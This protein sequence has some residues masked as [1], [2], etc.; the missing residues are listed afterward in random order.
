MF[1]VG[2]GAVASHELGAVVVSLV[3][4]EDVVL[5]AAPSVPPE[6]VPALPVEPSTVCVAGQDVALVVPVVVVSLA[7]VV[8]PA[9]VPLAGATLE[10]IVPLVPVVA[11]LVDELETTVL[12]TVP[13]FEVPI[14]V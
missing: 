8:V 9:L 4:L 11:L 5:A 6:V 13:V 14:V 3:A 12:E 1:V 7:V 10:S 2:S